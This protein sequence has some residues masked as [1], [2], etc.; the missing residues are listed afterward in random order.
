MMQQQ[1]LTS[2]D[3]LSMEQVREVHRLMDEYAG[4][5]AA[6]NLNIWLYLTGL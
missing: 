1:T 5:T 2:W 6:R 3:V 4:Q